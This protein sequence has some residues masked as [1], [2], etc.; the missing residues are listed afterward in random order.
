LNSSPMPHSSP[1]N[2]NRTGLGVNWRFVIWVMTLFLA[3]YPFI[4]IFSQL[5]TVDPALND[6]PISRFFNYAALILFSWIFIASTKSFS[7]ASL[8]LSALLL[9][10]LFANYALTDYAS[11]KWLLNWLGFVFISIVIVN[12]LAKASRFDLEVIQASILGTLNICSILLA[13]LLII[14]TFSNFSEIPIYNGTYDYSSAL[15]VLGCTVGI[16]KQA[17]GNFLCYLMLL[18]FHF[19][20][21]QSK[22]KNIL[23][24]ALI[25]L[26]IPVGLTTIRTLFL[27]LALWATW[28]FLTRRPRLMFASTIMLIPGMAFGYLYLSDIIIFVGGAYDRFSSLKFAFTTM[29]SMPFGLGNGG[30]HV[31]VADNNASLLANFAS[32]SIK[33]TGLFWGAP[34]SD[35]VYFIASWGVFS[36]IFYAMFFYLLF[37]GGFILRVFPHL[38]PIEKVF[39]SMSWA[40]IFMGISQ[41]NAGYLLWWIHMAAGY[42]IVLRHS[43]SIHSKVKTVEHFAVSGASK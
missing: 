16:E 39:I 37:K 38:L 25:V 33:K 26:L 7:P 21:H 41:D 40:M 34:E 32:E 3:W 36:I 23:F 11:T 22:K 12:V 31:F 30:Y 1:L 15:W 6:I 35:L 5:G 17:F 29:L 8:S 19:W 13:L 2:Y 24:V 4:N 27:G 20:R 14:Y 10:M 18:N 42:G 9:V 43:R 28:L